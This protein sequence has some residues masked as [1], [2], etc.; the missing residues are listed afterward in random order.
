VCEWLYCEHQV[1]EDQAARTGAAEAAEVAEAATA[2][3]VTAEVEAAKAATPARNGT[4][5]RMGD[6]A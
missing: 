4:K 3:T 6:G 5:S 1:E 2:V